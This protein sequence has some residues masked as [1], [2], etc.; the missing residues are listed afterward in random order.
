MKLSVLL[1]L[2]FVMAVAG[3]KAP[4]KPAITDDTIVTSQVN[5]ITLKHR[6]AVTPPAEFTQVNEP[7]RAQLIQVD[8]HYIQTVYNGCKDARISE[9]P[10]FAAEE[11]CRKEF[12]K[13][14]VRLA[15][16]R[17]HKESER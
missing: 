16:E 17:K 15:P 13:A 14:S 5:G 11:S 4:Q 1:S 8:P 3:C 10:L 9:K 12:R 2:L 6:H 7:Y